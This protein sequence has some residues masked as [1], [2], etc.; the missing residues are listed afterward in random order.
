MSDVL[1]SVQSEVI[2]ISDPARRPLQDGD[3]SCLT[4]AQCGTGLLT[5]LASPACVLVMLL[6]FFHESRSSNRSMSMS[7]SLECV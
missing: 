4:R 2:S 3:C 6:K 5:I 7:A 1:P